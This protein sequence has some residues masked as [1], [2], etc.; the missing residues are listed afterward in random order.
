MLTEM[1][2]HHCRIQLVGIVPFGAVVWIFC[3]CI[4]SASISKIVH[5]QDSHLG[6]RDVN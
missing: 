1:T 2:L 4:I 6:V 3:R 5:V